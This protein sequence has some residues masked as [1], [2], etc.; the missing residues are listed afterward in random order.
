ME[1]RKKILT[2]VSRNKQLKIVLSMAKFM[3]IVK[4]GI[5]KNCGDCQFSVWND[6]E[7][8]YKCAKPDSFDDMDCNKYDLSNLILCKERD[9]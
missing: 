2:F 7:C 1:I 5:T 9:E 8:E 3:V 6:D 4:E